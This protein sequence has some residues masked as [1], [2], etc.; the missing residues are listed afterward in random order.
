M[1]RRRTRSLVAALLASVVL[2]ACDSGDGGGAER[3]TDD[4]ASEPAVEGIACTEGV[5]GESGGPAETDVAVTQYQSV[6]RVA[7]DGDL[8]G[9]EVITVDFAD[10]E[11]HGINRD[12]VEELS[13]EEASGTLDGRPSGTFTQGTAGA[14]L[15]LGDAEV[16]LPAGEHV[17][18]VVYSANAVLAPASDVA[19]DWQLDLPV[20]DSGW[21]LDIAEATVTIELPAESGDVSCV[22]GA[23]VEA[24]ISG[25]GTSTLVVTAPE[26]PAGTGIRVLI[27]TDHDPRE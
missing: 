18:G 9:S 4:A 21:A 16:T 8:D 20:V 27:G 11:H 24:T 26:V 25:A 17:F 14:R 6:L 13:I 3:G 2:S 12:F 1:K 22:A 19:Q 15:T 7:D 23:G 5:V 10:S